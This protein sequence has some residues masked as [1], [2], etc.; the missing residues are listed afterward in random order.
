MQLSPR[1][2]VLSGTLATLLAAAGCGGGGGGNGGGP[3]APNPTGAVVTVEV[4]EH[5]FEPRSVTV[6]AG[7]TVRWVMRGAD[8]THT[9]T[10]TDGAF[11]SGTV[12]TR[13]G[14]TFERVFNEDGRTFNYAC[15]AH[16]ACCSMR[17]SVRVGDTA[18]PPNPGY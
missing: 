8:P 3:T 18:P 11:D 16:D 14:A 7:T 1:S 5:V 12:F 13:A 15:Q 17:G 9:V 4:S 6:T 2:L 10:A